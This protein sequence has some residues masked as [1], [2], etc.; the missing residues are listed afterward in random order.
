MGQANVQAAAQGTPPAAA[1][2][3]PTAAQE[4]SPDLSLPLQVVLA[5]RA[6]CWVSVSVDGKRMPGRLIKAGEKVHLSAGQSIVLTAG[7]AGALDYTNNN[8]PG[9]ALGSSGEVKTAVIT[10]TNY[11]TFIAR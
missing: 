10:T 7:D 9:R 6:D 11:Q 1:A 4:P 5:P 3:A 8:A 2:A